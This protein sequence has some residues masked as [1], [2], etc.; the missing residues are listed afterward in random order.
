M[1]TR[2]AEPLRATIEETLIEIRRKFDEQA[3]QHLTVEAALRKEATKARRAAKLAEARH[4]AQRARA[5]R[6]KTQAADYRRELIS[7][8]RALRTSI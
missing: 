8:R 3:L 2:N 1:T 5:A 7:A 4:D 6:Y